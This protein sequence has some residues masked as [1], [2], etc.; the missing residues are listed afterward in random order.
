MSDSIDLL[1]A[2]GRDA[3]LRRLSPE[4]LARRLKAAGASDVLAEATAQCDASLLSQEFG[5]RVM[6]QPNSYNSPFRDVPQP[7][8]VPSP[9][10]PEE[11]NEDEGEQQGQARS[12]KVH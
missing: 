5:A 2:V 4:D 9:G 7:L 6:Q 3:S 10:E 1:E 12:A 8:K 11:E